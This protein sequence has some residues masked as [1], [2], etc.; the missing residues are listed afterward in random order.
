MVICHG[1]FYIS[2]SNE[3]IPKIHIGDKAGPSSLEHLVVLKTW[4][5]SLEVNYKNGIFQ[6]FEMENYLIRKVF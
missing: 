2:E 4:Q 6:A 1:V 3:A 5:R